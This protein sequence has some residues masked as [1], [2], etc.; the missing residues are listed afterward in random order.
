MRTPRRLP[1][2]SS[3]ALVA[4]TGL[5]LASCGS[6]P[7]EANGTSSSA[8]SAKVGQQVMLTLQTTGPGEYSSPPAVS[9]DVVRFLDVQLVTPAVPA[10]V[11][12]KFRFQA[13]RSGEAVIVFHHTAQA[14]HIEDTIRVN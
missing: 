14:A 9:S 12:Q 7:L 11:T 1:G 13:M 8:F 2:S 5:V 4:A 6:N 10:G 3:L